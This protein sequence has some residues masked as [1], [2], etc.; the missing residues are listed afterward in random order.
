VSRRYVGSLRIRTDLNSGGNRQPAN[1]ARTYALSGRPAEARK[2]LREL[3]DSAKEHYVPAMYIAGIYAAL[4]EKGQS[5]MWIQKAYDERSDYMVYL[6]TEPSV[7][8]FRSNK[9]FQALLTRIAREPQ[10]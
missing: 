6:K 9:R 3:E 5:L 10:P 2:V 4:G 7:D 1:I 8:M